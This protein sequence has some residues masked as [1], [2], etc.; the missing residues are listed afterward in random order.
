[1]RSLVKA[2]SAA[3]H[4]FTLTT[5]DP[6]RKLQDRQNRLESRLSRS[7]RVL[8]ASSPSALARWKTDSNANRT[9]ANMIA[10]QT[11]FSLSSAE[12]IGLVIRGT[13]RPLIPATVNSRADDWELL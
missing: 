1:M 6:S 2:M 8:A 4:H 3:Y 9:Q 13:A 7:S 11:P 12:R 10:T 5:G